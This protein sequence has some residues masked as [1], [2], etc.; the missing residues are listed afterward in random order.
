MGASSV[1]H[2]IVLLLLAALWTIPLWVVV[3][4]AGRSPWISLLGIIPLGAIV[5]LWWLAFAHWRP[6]NNVQPRV[7]MT[8]IT[9]GFHRIGLVLSV[10]CVVVGSALLSVGVVMLATGHS[11]G[12]QLVA[13]ALPW[14]LFAAGLFAL[15][16]GIA[17][18]VEGFQ[19]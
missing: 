10:P 7:P 19:R 18:V 17:W 8:S 11:G 14:M 12:D 5:V 13:L 16:R 6:L 9:R 2:W 1:W 3:R 4:R 15:S